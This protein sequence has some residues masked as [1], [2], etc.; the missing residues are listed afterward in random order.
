MKKLTPELKKRFKTDTGI[1]VDEELSA[2]FGGKKKAPPPEPSFM[3]GMMGEE[4]V[5]AEAAHE[6][7]KAAEDAELNFIDHDPVDVSISVEDY[8]ELAE[9]QPGDTVRLVMEGTLSDDRS[10]IQATK[11]AVVHGALDPKT[12]IGAGLKKQRPSFVR[13]PPPTVRGY[14]GQQPPRELV[15]GEPRR[16]AP[17][18]RDPG[19]VGP[20]PKGGGAYV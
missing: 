20:R 1:D 11:T 17:G 7:V 4:P 15:P 14:P 9:D 12:L 8:P 6:D 3:P 18:F 19:Q 2:A 5:G 10:S 16:H 13:P